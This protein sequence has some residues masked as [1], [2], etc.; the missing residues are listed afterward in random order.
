MMYLK[1]SSKKNTKIFETQPKGLVTWRNQ[2][3]NQSSKREVS[4]YLIV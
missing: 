4:I 1:K 3:K 2:H